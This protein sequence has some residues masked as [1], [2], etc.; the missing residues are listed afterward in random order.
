MKELLEDLQGAVD[1]NQRLIQITMARQLEIMRLLITP[2]GRREINAEILDCTGEDC[3][4]YPAFEICPDGS[5][6]WNCGD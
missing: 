2:N 1:E 5:L 6:D 4:V 3:P